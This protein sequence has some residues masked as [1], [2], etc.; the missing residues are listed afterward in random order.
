[1]PFIIKKIF[2]TQK[3]RAFSFLKRELELS[4]REIQRYIAIGRVLVNGAPI[5]KPSDYLQ[6]EV[7]YIY[8]EPISKG[9]A[10]HF[11]EERFV[12]FDKPSGMLIHPQNRFTEYSL[13]D[14][15]KA[16]F[17]MNANIAHRIDQETSGLVLCAKD[18]K[19]E[20]DIKMMF[21][22]RDM[23]K[24]YLAMVHGELKEELRIDAPL[25]RYDDEKS[26][27]VRMVVKVDPTGKESLTFVRPLKY[28]PI[29]DTTL[30]E[31]SPHTGRQHQIRVHMFHMKHPIV[32]DPV[33][34]QSEESVVR[35]LDRKIERD[36]RVKLSGAK[37]LLLH[38]NELEFELYGKKH[39]IKSSVNFEKICF[40]N[41]KV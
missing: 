21:Q 31:C 25:L 34:G 10:P 29:T 37:R 26:A 11:I 23:K 1:M 33:Y 18:K 13:I 7:E 5:V 15:L 14:E 40:E 27:L 4:Q 3:E 28:F 32:G 41:M 9:L 30:V 39:I 38:A 6:G 8:F 19:S 35:Y 24:K 12:V 16:Q 22:E 36:E 20:V 2:A 17:G